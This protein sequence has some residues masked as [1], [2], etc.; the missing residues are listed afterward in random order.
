MQ[1]SF[2]IDV[3]LFLSILIFYSYKLNSSNI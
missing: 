3:N 2:D 1:E